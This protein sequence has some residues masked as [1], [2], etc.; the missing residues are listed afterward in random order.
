MRSCNYITVFVRDQYTTRSNLNC[1]LHTELVGIIVRELTQIA[2]F[3]GPIWGPPGSC[4][5]QMGPMLVPWTLLSGK[6]PKK[7]K[8]Y[9]GIRVSVFL[10][11]KE[12]Y[13]S[14]YYFT[15]GYGTKRFHITGAVTDPCLFCYLMC[16]TRH[17]TGGT[18][19]LFSLALWKYFQNE[20]NCSERKIFLWRKFVSSMSNL[21]MQK[22][23]VFLKWYHTRKIVGNLKRCDNVVQR[24]PCSKF[25][26]TCQL[27]KCSIQTFLSWNNGTNVF[28]LCGMIKW[29][30]TKHIFY[31]LVLQNVSQSNLLWQLEIRLA[32]YILINLRST[33]QPWLFNTNN[34]TI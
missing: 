8:V 24:I 3:M 13:S 16:Y 6:C 12:P 27:H 33:Y 19:G 30:T 11:D 29:D 9:A 15:R 7:D 1:T 2:K 23:R 20:I 5:P 4:R 21:L 22:L 26:I 34:F 10:K 18:P 17:S 28:I 25:R 32:V 31:N 14:C